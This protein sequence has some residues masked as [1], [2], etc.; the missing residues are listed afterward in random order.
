LEAYKLELERIKSALEAEKERI[1]EEQNNLK[2]TEQERQE[3]SL[4]TA[5]L[6]KEI[7]EYRMRSNSLSEE[8]EDLR[9]QRQENTR[10][11]WRVCGVRQQSIGPLSTKQ[12][13]EKNNQDT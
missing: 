4:L 7:E 3:H 8:M 13:A 1:S 6:K 10:T 5:K 2:L 9:K 12:V 11:S